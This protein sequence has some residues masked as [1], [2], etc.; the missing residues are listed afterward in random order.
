MPIFDNELFNTP[1]DRENKIN[2]GVIQS[3]S[4]IGLNKGLG[5]FGEQESSSTGLS[6]DEIANLANTPNSKG[7]DSPVQMI[8]QSE[9]LEN[10]RYG[11]YERGID[12]EEYHALGQ[13]AGEQW[14]NSLVKMGATA[15]GTFA[16]SFG[17]IPNAIS[18]IRSGKISDFSDP[19]GYEASIDNWLKNLEDNFPNF[20]SKYEKEHPFLTAIPFTK[21]SANFWGDKILKNLGFI[22]G[23]IG[24]AVVQD[25]AIGAVTSGMGGVPLISSQIGKA[26]LYLGKLFSRSSDVSKVLEAAK[27]TGIAGEELL[28][29]TKLA[30]IAKGGQ[31]LDKAA[32][33]SRYALSLYSS[34]AAEAGVEARD[35]YR[36]V[37][38]NLIKQY[39]DEHLGEEPIGSDL[40]QINKYAEDA[41]NVRFGINMALLTVSNAIQFDSFLKTFGKAKTASGSLTRS[42]EEAGKI[43]L[44]EGSLDVFEKKVAPTVV[45]K[46]WDSIKPKL[47]EIFSEGVY[48][49]GGQYA[50]ERGTYDYYTRKYKDPYKG[51][52]RNTW[53]SLN[54][55]IDS[56]MYGLKQQF[57]TDE[58][59]ENMLLGALTAIITGGAKKTY[60]SIKGQGSN[61]QIQNA[62]NTLNQYGLTG[63]LSNKYDNTGTSAAISKEM[64]EAVKSG[65][66]FKFKNLKSDVFFNYVMSRIPSGLHDVTIEQLEMLKDLPKE[67]FEKTFG[68]DFNESSKNTVEGYVDKLI[69]KANNIKST[70]EALD[71]M[72]KNPFNNIIDPKTEEEQQEKNF[73][74][75][76]NEW[77]TDLAYYS[78][79]PFDVNNR[80]Q[81]IGNDLIKIHPLLNTDI[82]GKLTSKKGL[83]SLQKEYQQKA[84]DLEKTITEFTSPEDKRKINREI[85]TLNSMSEKVSLGLLTP[86]VNG[87][88][89]HDILNFEVNNQDASK[90]TVI[91]IEKMQDAYTYG[92]DINR[93][94][95]RKKR[96]ND[97]YDGLSSKEGFQ[98][99][100]EQAEE[101]QKEAEQPLEQKEYSFINSKKKREVAEV[102]KEY[103]LP[104]I[105]TAYWKKEK[106]SYNVYTP[107]GEVEKYDT[108]EAAD[109]AMNDIN[110]D[111]NALAKV[112][113]VAQNADGTLKI[114]DLS[115]TIQNIKPETLQS[116]SRIISKE[117]QLLK[118]KSQ[119]D[120][121]QNKFEAFSPTV[122]TG[123]PTQEDKVWEEPK[124]ATNKF[125]ISTITE[126]E[127]LNDPTQSA[128]HI[129]RARKF[130][131]EA[132]TFRNRNKL[133]VI[134][135][136]P[137]QEDAYGLTGL[138][139]L[140]YPNGKNLTDVDNGL[141]VAVF[142]ETDRNKLY[143][144]NENGRR[145]SEVG[146]PI[147]VNSVVFQTMP[148][149]AIEDSTGQPR[150]R[151]G[152]QEEFEKQSKTWRATRESLFASTGTPKV[153]KFNISRGI[154]IEIPNQLNYVGNTLIEEKKIPTKEG[155]IK[156]SK[157]GTLTRNGETITVPKGRPVLINDD[158][159][160]P[161]QN[162]KLGKKKATNIFHTIK[163]QVDELLEANENKKPLKLNPRFITYLQNVL[164][165]TNKKE[166]KAGN[167]FLIDTSKMSIVIGDTEYRFS[168]I[169]SRKDQIIDQ[170]TNIYHNINDTTLTKKFNDSFYE[171]VYNENE[172]KW[173]DKEWTNYQTYLLSSENRTVEETPLVTSIAKPS[174]GVPY[175]H[176]A[177]Y[178]TLID[179]EHPSTEQKKT[180]SKPKPVV[181][182]VEEKKEEVPS[183]KLGEYVLDGVTENIFKAKAGDI[184][185]TASIDE[186]N[187]INVSANISEDILEKSGLTADFITKVI[188]ANLVKLQKAQEA[189]KVEEIKK[190][191][192]KQEGFNLGNTSTPKDEYR[193]IGEEDSERITNT[194][195][196]L[197]K[198]WTKN[199]VP[200]I[201]YEILENI[202]TIND[203]EKAWG[204]FEEGIAKFYK[205]ALKGTEYHEVFEG[206]FKSMLSTEQRQ[207]LINEFKS[208]Q[209]EFIDRQTGKK[210]EYSKATDLQAKER[211]ADDFADFR[212]GKIKVKS[213]GEKMKD[214]FRSII[215]FFKSFI[216][217]PSLKQQLFKAID[218]GK[219][220]EKT[221]EIQSTKTS[222]F[223][224]LKQL[225]EKQREELINS[226]PEVNVTFLSGKE[227]VNL[228]NS[229]QA[230][231]KQQELV[232]EYQEIQ[233]IINC[234]WKSF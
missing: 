152:Q 214:F 9:L 36:Q 45:G 231:I 70:V 222:Q 27:A 171:L 232:Q 156:I 230:K 192:P 157:E 71:K 47:P 155:L 175:T 7:W 91:P 203:N 128:P 159:F 30:Q 142:I 138:S 41:M 196:E 194:E 85:K 154:G 188:T 140:S 160:E 228:E 177:K 12:L 83:E 114:E 130:L 55:T 110:K 134:L 158:T 37:K 58:G 120:K 8:P 137:N 99:Y 209:G 143:Y 213:L 60:D 67:E 6:L 136:T 168:E 19:D 226:K 205:G 124:K 206:I 20:Y 112:K 54:E 199:N 227:L 193:K 51:E 211:I 31:L 162:N 131:N 84:K 153:Y 229:E 26:S 139:N 82:V 169:E 224:L 78:N 100:F 56:T 73:Y 129:K 163:S 53:D 16:Q 225:E 1:I 234:L 141:V 133:G 61:A 18:A 68:M 62:V 97:I 104:T 115:G 14:W 118:N 109:K 148:T 219:F 202:I 39:K 29:V 106:D 127:E 32:N 93:L 107:T 66:V 172:N 94:N 126:S 40:E 88:M 22:I 216:S 121:E 63:V 96:V 221:L 150:Y 191:L 210:I 38:E 49:E 50:A 208:Q 201:P 204:V 21:G 170:L 17:T 57:G 24:G 23:A 105:K 179:F 113:V 165:Y 80:L 144:I 125:F 101:I 10:K 167:K 233:K 187:N 181:P 189:P 197:F 52:N 117:E 89:F 5:G 198:E 35:G 218:T 108:P 79:V 223:R 43:G 145:L 92:V 215:E 135:V 149:T 161:L 81:S 185:F 13:G 178:A 207:A 2:A 186:E 217:K 147:D 74:K 166:L 180:V 72:Y 76:F 42:I 220:K 122:P 200:N 48:E 64:N 69:D 33:G 25:A 151:K 103:E 86:E 123:N 164:Y 4:T 174:E 146:Q 34:S 59:L 182:V 87:R 46:V 119:L 111:I 190:E 195:I 28:N 11:M 77:K 75:T 95:D 132:K 98:K 15:A 90:D 102:G 176:K 184:P 3:P 173:E 212:L 183:I 65:D 44:K 116:Y